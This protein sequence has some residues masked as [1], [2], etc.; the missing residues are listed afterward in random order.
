MPDGATRKIN[1]RASVNL[2][3]ENTWRRGGDFSEVFCF[4]FG[5]LL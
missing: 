1:D 4:V 3:M 5:V 2:A